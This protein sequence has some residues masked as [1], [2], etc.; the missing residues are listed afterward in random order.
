MKTTFTSV[1]KLIALSLVLLGA[2]LSGCDD[3]V[4]EESPCGEGEAIMADGRIYCVFRSRQKITEEGFSCPDGFAFGH[5]YGDLAICGAVEGALPPE[6]FDALENAHTGLAEGS[7]VRVS[8]GLD[9]ACDEG[10]CVSDVESQCLSLC[11]EGCPAPEFQLCGEDGTLYC[12]TCE[13]ACKGVAEA[14]DRSACEQGS[15]EQCIDDCRDCSTDEEP[16]LTGVPP[17]YWLCG[18]DG[19]LYEDS[20]DI[21]CRGLTE[22]TDRTTCQ[23]AEDC[24]MDHCGEE[25][26]MPPEQMCGEDGTLYCTTCEM[27][28]NGVNEASDPATCGS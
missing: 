13:M 23:S 16:C 10:V 9:Q 20:C 24:T 2:A 28:C 11:G 3:T 18:S 27:A 1:A 7:C 4:T 21:S 25:C 15:V 26:P 8:C 14:S 5:G 22:V 12:N 17:W 6:F 19:N